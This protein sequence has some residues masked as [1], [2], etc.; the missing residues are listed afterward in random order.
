MLV[1]SLLSL[2]IPLDCMISLRF[3]TLR[4][5]TI[6]IITRERN[7]LARYTHAGTVWSHCPLR[8]NWSGKGS[9]S[10]GSVDIKKT[11]KWDDGLHEQD[12]FHF[13][14]WDFVHHNTHTRSPLPQPASPPPPDPVI[15]SSPRPP[16]LRLIT[17]SPLICC[18]SPALHL[19]SPLVSFSLVPRRLAPCWCQG[20]Q[21]GE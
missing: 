20:R 11:L 7:M 12:I 17:P 18:C 8:A 5:C 21:R 10:S 4:R 16:S 6:D 2:K 19:F 14:H 3:L 1:F 13:P 15:L 9:G